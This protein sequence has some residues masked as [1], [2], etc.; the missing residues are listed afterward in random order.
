MPEILARET[1]D[2]KNFTLMT[3]VKGKMLCDREYLTDVPRLLDLAAQAL[4]RMWSVD[5][6]LCPDRVSR[7]DGRLSRARHNVE[8]GFVDTEDAEEG[9]FGP[10]GFASPAALLSWLETHRPEEDLVL[11]HGDCCLPNLFADGDSVS[12]YI[13]V[14]KMGPADRWQDIA[15]CIRSISHNLDGRYSHGRKYGDF[16]PGDLLDRLGIPMDEE[17]YRYYLLLDELF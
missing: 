12:G 1:A 3:R 5:I 6:T 13:D 17:K 11:T 9:T 16:A 2:G 8:H 4:R 15:L 7:L 14:G 10:N